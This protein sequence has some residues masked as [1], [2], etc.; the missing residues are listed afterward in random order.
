MTNEVLIL[1]TLAFL[2]FLAY[3]I[4]RRFFRTD[5][6]QLIRPRGKSDDNGP[7]ASGVPIRFPPDSGEAQ[8]LIS[9][10]KEEELVRKV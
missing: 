3:L 2:F 4:W 5:F 7:V 1:L 6:D 10:E 9:I 8:E